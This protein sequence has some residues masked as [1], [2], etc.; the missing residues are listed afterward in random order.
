MKKHEI[1]WCGFRIREGGAPDLSESGD[2]GCAYGGHVS[3]SSSQSWM[4]RLELRGSKA[5]KS[6]PFPAI[7][8]CQESSARRS[9]QLARMN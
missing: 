5:V 6:N 3:K 8:S 1:K 2:K 4:L 9:L 7:I